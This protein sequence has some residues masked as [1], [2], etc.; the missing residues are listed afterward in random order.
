MDKWLTYTQ[1]SFIPT[2]TQ[3]CGDAFWCKSGF[4]SWMFTNLLETWSQKRRLY[5]GLLLERLVQVQSKGVLGVHWEKLE[6]GESLS[7]V[8]K[9]CTISWRSR[10]FC[11]QKAAP[12]PKALVGMKDHCPAPAKPRFPILPE[13]TILGSQS[14][15]YVK[16]ALLR[17][18]YDVLR[19]ITSW[20][21][22]WV[23]MWS[24]VN[25]VLISLLLSIPI[26]DSMDLFWVEHPA[27]S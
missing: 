2:S 22:G 15:F 20:T 18:S 10:V 4:L 26:S 6:S 21:S 5:A 25:K 1:R 9:R 12:D 16:L 3:G 7:L 27:H 19:S 8:G 23:Y 24:D 14:T 17:A 13:M 11:T